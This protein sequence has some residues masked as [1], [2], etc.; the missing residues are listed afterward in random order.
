ML[1]SIMMMDGQLMVLPFF[2]VCDGPK[3]VWWQFAVLAKSVYVHLL[4]QR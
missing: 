4:I 3:R 1:F 2:A